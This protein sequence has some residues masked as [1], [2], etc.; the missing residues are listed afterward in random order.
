MLSH[1]RR[2]EKR[3]PSSSS[4]ISKQ[5]QPPTL[6]FRA[7][8][9]F[10]APGPHT[11]GEMPSARCG[12]FFHALNQPCRSRRV[13]IAVKSYAHAQQ[14][15][16]FRRCVASQ[17]WE[18]VQ[19][20]YQRRPPILAE[21]R[22]WAEEGESRGWRGCEETVNLGGTLLSMQFGLPR[23]S[24]LRLKCMRCGRCSSPASTFASCYSLPLI[25]Q[26]EPDQLRRLRKLVW[27]PGRL[28]ILSMP[29]PCLTGMKLNA[30][31]RLA[32]LR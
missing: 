6:A 21:K 7:F 18:A 1:G 20:R 30:A 12:A 19:H 14:P 32:R 26:Y 2:A 28:V 5:P 27:N 10:L 29:G 3:N 8:L 13:Y 4:G 24:R 15:R 25:V 17:S 16:R 11:L 23:W 9:E 22:T 31:D